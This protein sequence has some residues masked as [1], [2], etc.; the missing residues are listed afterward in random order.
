MVQLGVGWGG[1]SLSLVIIFGGVCHESASL[2]HH[3]RF[4]LIFMC[5]FFCSA[6]LIELG[7]PNANL[8][9]LCVLNTTG[10]Q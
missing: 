4:D 5:V 9:T 7:Y 8:T 3:S 2:F 6:A 10:T 1:V